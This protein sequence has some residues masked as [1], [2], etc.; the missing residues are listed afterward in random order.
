MA[1]T[2]TVNTITDSGVEMQ[3]FCQCSFSLSVFALDRTARSDQSQQC[4]PQLRALEPTQASDSVDVTQSLFVAVESRAPWTDIILVDG[5]FG[6]SSC[7]L[8]SLHRPPI[9]K[10]HPNC[11]RRLLHNCSFDAGVFLLSV[12]RALLA[13][14]LTM[15]ICSDFLRVWIPQATFPGLQRPPLLEA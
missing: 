4:A 7:A 2:L 9:R 13:V 5:P 10:V 6:G 1:A 15:G 14:L 11:T 3:Y 12:V 8:H